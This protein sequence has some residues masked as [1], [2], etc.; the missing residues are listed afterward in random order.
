MSNYFYPLNVGREAWGSTMSPKWE[1]TE[2]ISASGRRRAL[3]EQLYPKW[4]FNLQYKALDKQEANS[5]LAFYGQRRGALE[6]FYYKDYAQ[7]EIKAQQLPQ[8]ADGTYQLVANIG[9]YVEPVQV[10]DNLKVYV[11]GNQ[12]TNYTVNNG[13]VT[14]TGSGTVTADYDYYFKVRF[15]GDI[16]FTEIFDGFY[17][18]SV[19]LE[20]VR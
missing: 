20:G 2:H 5:L 14:V 1:T 19:T 6:P 16:S 4:Q 18:V 11:G 15:A 9:G 10:V 7:H 8:N 12:V 13:K 3:C 17:N